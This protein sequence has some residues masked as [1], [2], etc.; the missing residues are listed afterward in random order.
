MTIF[1]NC[2]WICVIYIIYELIDNDNELYLKVRLDYSSKINYKSTHKK[3]YK[4]NHLNNLVNKRN[5]QI[6]YDTSDKKIQILSITDKRNEQISHDTSDDKKIQIS[7]KLRITNNKITDNTVEA[8]SNNDWIYP[9]ENL[10]SGG[11][12]HEFANNLIYECWR[13]Q[14]SGSNLRVFERWNQGGE[15]CKKLFHYIRHGMR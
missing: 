9:S 7:E 6:S 3:Y 12:K 5:E 15:P 14:N 10:M 11:K 1:E 4:D 2:F 13:N 8:I